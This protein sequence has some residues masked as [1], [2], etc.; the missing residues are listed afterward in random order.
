[1]NHY[2]KESPLYLYYSK[3]LSSAFQ[4]SMNYFLQ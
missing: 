1:M 2:C 4:T 3:I